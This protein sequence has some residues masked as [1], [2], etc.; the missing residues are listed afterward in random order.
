[1]IDIIT[2]GWGATQSLRH[3]TL[4]LIIHGHR[5]MHA[6]L[7][8]NA[9]HGI[10]ML[11]IAKLARLAGIDQLH[12]GTVVGKMEGDEGD[13]L[14]VNKFLLSDWY[15][16]K[17]VLSIASGGLHP[18]LVSELVRILGKDVII[19]FGGGIH[20]HPDGTLAGA[21]AARQAVEAAMKKIPLRKYPENHEDLRVALE[22][23]K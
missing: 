7:T 15:G 16:L 4:G 21:R 20:G 5:A 8:R 6:A 1:M 13:V 22:K 9:H 23:W 14:A 11:V 18:A 17:P 10:S 2:A 3:E 19:N 12:T